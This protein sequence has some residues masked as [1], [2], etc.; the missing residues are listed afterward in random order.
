[1][2]TGGYERGRWEWKGA[3]VREKNH[4]VTI[5]LSLNSNGY[6][7][8]KNTRTHKFRCD[9]SCAT[10]ALKVTVPGGVI[11]MNKNERETAEVPSG[12]RGRRRGF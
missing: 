11:I 10:A 8:V 12:E 6:E 1:M 3:C 4:N 7:L 9:L 2:Y 5:T